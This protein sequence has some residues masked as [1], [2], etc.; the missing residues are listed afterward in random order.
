M[1]FTVLNPFIKLS[2]VEH[3]LT[4]GDSHAVS[5]SCRVLIFGSSFMILQSVFFAF[6]GTYHTIQL[7][8]SCQDSMSLFSRPLFV[9]KLNILGVFSTIALLPMVK[10]QRFINGCT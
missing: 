4:F 2:V 5:N 6:A 7:K 10:F 3:E 1:F 8:Q 9:I